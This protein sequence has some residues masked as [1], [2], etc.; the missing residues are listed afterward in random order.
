VEH[1]SAKCPI[2]RMKEIG[3]EEELFSFMETYQQKQKTL[4]MIPTSH[5]L[6]YCCCRSE[7]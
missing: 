3:V 6:P 2:K 4:M 5:F 7:V 1:F